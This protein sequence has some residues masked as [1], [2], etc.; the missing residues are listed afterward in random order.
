MSSS[1]L[2]IYLHLVWATFKRMDLI[3]EELEPDLRNLI[4]DKIIENKSILIAFGCTSD[5]I[6]LLLNL[7][8]AVSIAT[9]VGEIK[10]YSS[11][12]ISNKI[13]SDCGFRWQGGYGAMSISRGDL[14]RLV[15]YINN[16]K[17]HHTSD[18]LEQYWEL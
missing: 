10:G 6:H 13:H 1:Y 5:H 11:F 2:H 18:N 17:E 9:I 4:N 14:P 16:Q 12:I 8:P 15:K 3:A 7:H